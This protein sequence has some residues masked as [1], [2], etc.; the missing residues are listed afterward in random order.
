MKKFWAFITAFLFLVLSV[1]QVLAVPTLEITSFP[2][3][4]VAGEEFIV[5][6]SASALDPEVTY[7]AKGVGGDNLYDIE[8]WSDK[9]SGWLN[10]NGP[11]PDMPEFT[12]LADGTG[13]FSTKV[14]FKNDTLPGLK[15]FLIRIRKVGTESN[16]NSSTIQI[17]VSAPT[18][19][20]TPQPTPSPSPTPTPS[21]PTPSPTKTPTPKPTVKA[22]TASE[23][24]T[25][26]TP[27]GEIL[28]LREGLMADESPS[29]S[30]EGE[31]KGFPFFAILLIVGGIGFMG[32]AGYSF[33]KSKKEE[34]Y[35]NQSE[36][37]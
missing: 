37:S 32:A 13:I 2:T 30:A 20:P 21:P 33:Y 14:K 1:S 15:D 10:W 5:Q 17:S 27:N 3:S 36:K 19:S 35:N 11:W 26:S 25:F 24:Q 4:S 18:P 23:P 29:S 22:T 31:K 16:Y 8:T 9:T 28:G 34:G 12:S 6:F 7:Y